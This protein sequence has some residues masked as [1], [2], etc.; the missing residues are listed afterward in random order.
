MNGLD[1]LKR[2]DGSLRRRLL[3][4][5]PELRTI[6]TADTVDWQE[7][8]FEMTEGQRQAMLELLS[9]CHAAREAILGHVVGDADLGA[10][11][12]LRHHCVAGG[13]RLSTLDHA[14]TAGNRAC[15]CCGKPT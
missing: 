6:A 13:E 12:A 14:I 3:S 10:E 8:D 9:A 11:R 5:P 2:L 1:L 4:A 7:P 15:G